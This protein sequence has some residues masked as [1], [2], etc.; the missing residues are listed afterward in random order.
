[1]P[2][3]ASELNIALPAIAADLRVSPANVIWIVNVYRI[4]GQFD[5]PICLRP[6]SSSKRVLL[7]RTRRDLTELMPWV[8]TSP[9]SRDKAIR[10]RGFR[11]P[12]IRYAVRPKPPSHVWRFLE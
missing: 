1:M 8:G 7:E 6:V 9:N 11:A 4:D 5:P 12:A 3:R 10:L 2:V